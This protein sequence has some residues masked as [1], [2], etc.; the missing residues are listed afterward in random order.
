M[1]LFIVELRRFW[2]RRITWMTLLV[3]CLC[4]LGA[5]AI[6]FTQHDGV[7]ATEVDGPIYFDGCIEDLTRLR[8]EGDPEFAGL[9]DQEIADQY[10]VNTFDD[11]DGRFFATLILSAQ[12]PTDWSEFKE[13]TGD[14]PSMVVNGTT[15]ES[16][17]FGLDGIL[18]GV[19][20]FL[21]IVAVVLGGS[22]IGA[23]YRSGTVE[24]LL[25]W[26]P[27]RMK[28]LATKAAAGFVS[29]AGVSSILA[30]WLTGLLLVL[31]QLRGTFDGVDATFWTDWVLVVV[32]AGVMAGCFFVL[33]M[34]IATLSRNTTAAV[35]ALLGWFVISNIV[36]EVFA[37]PVRQYELFT[38]AAAFV[39]G[40][41]V[42]RYVGSSGF[43]LVF[44]HGPGVAAAIVAVW[45]LVP[46]VAA[47]AVFKGRDVS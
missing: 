26:E 47:A 12:E 11:G 28:V 20:V 9:S 1:R 41:D 24:N 29:A 25:L 14:R 38:N 3:V 27:R 19:S 10:C 5:V 16:A 30:A 7:A 44:S 15:Y 32:R 43:D 6:A 8:D 4:I 21:L 34:A 22:F 45:F 36:I 35:A 18:P 37:R 17:R 42:A 23:E 46:S 40:G 31:A 2:S 39:G 13:T 33:A